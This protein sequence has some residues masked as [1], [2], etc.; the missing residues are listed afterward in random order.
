MH[1][2]GGLS[3]LKRQRDKW[4]KNSEDLPPSSGSNVINTS[5]FASTSSHRR[6]AASFDL[7]IT[8][9]DL[10]HFFFFLFKQRVCVDNFFRRRLNASKVTP[11]MEWKLLIKTEW[12]S[13]GDRGDQVMLHFS[14][15]V[16]CGDPDVLEC[17]TWL[18]F[19]LLW[20]FFFFLCLAAVFDSFYVCAVGIQFHATRNGSLHTVGEGGTNRWRYRRVG[21]S[22][23]FIK[24]ELFL[25]Q[26]DNRSP[27]ST[28]ACVGSSYR[29]RAVRSYR[30]CR[31]R[32]RVAPFSERSIV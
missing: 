22:W 28:V 16:L 17:C 4:S 23:K 24:Y 18:C 7:F 9:I 2:L 32:P 1:T 29:V 8:T 14:S 31:C 12:G 10:V 11:K 25:V 21:A 30:S 19:D 27:R 26:N 3:L 13:G 5:F 6:R 15:R 20:L